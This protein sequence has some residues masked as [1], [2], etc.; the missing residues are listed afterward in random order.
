MCLFLI[1]KKNFWKIFLKLFLN[2]K[3]TKPIAKFCQQIFNDET[4]NFYAIIVL[5]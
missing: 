1:R 4:S 3:F 5:K 2:H